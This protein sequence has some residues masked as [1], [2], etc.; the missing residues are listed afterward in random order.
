MRASDEALVDRAEHIFVAQ[1][2]SAAYIPATTEEEFEVVVA[3][4]RVTEV[5]KGDPSF[6]EQ[7]IGGLGMGNCSI[8]FTVGHHLLVYTSDSGELSLC[9]GT[10]S[11]L[12]WDEEIQEYFK[13]IRGYVESGAEIVPYEGEDW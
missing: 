12:P 2:V 8:P 9:S 10:R 13:S 7:L 3:D 4:F 11:I 1:I 6:I 5:L